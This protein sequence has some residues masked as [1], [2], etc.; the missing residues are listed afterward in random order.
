[1]G[2][3]YIKGK[4]GMNVSALFANHSACKRSAGIDIGHPR[5]RDL[6]LRMAAKADIVV[7][8]FSPGVMERHGL[9]FDELRAVN[10]DIIM[11]RMS[12]QGADGPRGHQPGLGTHIQ[13]LSGIDDLTGF[14]GE[15]PGGPNAV[16][17]DLVGAPV[18][19]IALLSALEHR[20][21]TGRGQC[22]ELSQ[23]ESLLTLVQPALVQT[24]IEGPPA[25][26][27]NRSLSVCPHGVYP[28]VGEEQ[29]IAIAAES[30][31]DW[32]T[33]RALLPVSAR[34]AL[35]SLRTLAE[36]KQRED[37]IDRF[38]GERTA[39]QDGD[40]LATR[41]QAA[42]IAAYPLLPGAAM[43][44]DPQL[45]ARGHYWYP[46]HP[47]CGRVPVDGPVFRMDHVAPRVFPAPRYAAD[48][49]DILRDWLG[50]GDDDLAD[51]MADGV[52]V[53]E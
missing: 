38:I 14:P 11:L 33:L 9:S 8:N 35:G 10:P 46:D 37:D 39:A 43:T 13:T 42:G 26:M 53:T 32:E 44:T 47:V 25:R 28:T 17:P 24:Q 6:L 49:G 34:A 1:M 12:I 30:D 40:S 41:L 45:V 15:L 23:F 2:S 16:L 22:I 50:L 5:A 20:R 29:W 21:Q 27:G 3:P 18:A 7:E 48:T 52:V 36:R 31:A 51:L 4:P 19:L